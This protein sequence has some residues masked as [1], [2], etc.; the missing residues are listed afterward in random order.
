MGAASAATP[1][2]WGRGG[3]W[4]SPQSIAGIEAAGAPRSSP[5]GGGQR[6]GGGRLRQLFRGGLSLLD[7]RAVA[8]FHKV[9]KKETQEAEEAHLELLAVLVRALSQRVA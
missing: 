7:D 2:G 9:A 8:S 1:R 6:T 3:W 5:T 4:L